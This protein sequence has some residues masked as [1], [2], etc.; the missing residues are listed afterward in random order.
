MKSSILFAAF[1][2]L[3]Q[4]PAGPAQQ[5]AAK[6]RIEGIVLRTETGDAV[7]GAR[8]MLTRAGARGAAPMA[9]APVP[10][11]VPPPA[12]VRGAP[13]SPPATI[14]S[15]NTDDQGKFAFQDLDAGTYTMQIL[16]NGFVSQSY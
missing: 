8:I 1:A 14:P 7:R 13:P 5:P 4:I 11:P 12:G 15:V 10:I 6:S 16:A 9:G 2:A 3:L